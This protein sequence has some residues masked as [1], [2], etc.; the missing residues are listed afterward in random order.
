MTEK[1]NIINSLS[2]RMSL[3]LLKDYSWM[4]GNIRYELEMTDLCNDIILNFLF[5]KG[6]GTGRI[7]S[8]FL[9]TNKI[10]LSLKKFMETQNVIKLGYVDIIKQ[11]DTYYKLKINDNGRNNFL[12]YSKKLEVKSVSNIERISIYILKL[13]RKVWILVFVSGNSKLKSMMDSGIIKLILFIMAVL[14]FILK[15]EIK[16][17]VLGWLNK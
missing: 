14:T 7:D 8:L 1:D 11:T 16:E 12:N 15:D 9:Q 4:P 6:E 13:I 5:R 10:P 17:W 3:K 2:E